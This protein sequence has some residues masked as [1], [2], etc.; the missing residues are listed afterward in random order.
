MIR[1]RSMRAG[2]R[3]RG[4]AAAGAAA[5]SG[6]RRPGRRRRP[7]AR[8]R[9]RA[10]SAPARPGERSVPTRIQVVRPLAD[11][12]D[13]LQRAAPVA[14]DAVE[15]V[16]AS[17]G[18][19]PEKTARVVASRP[20]DADPRAARCRPGCRRRQTV[21]RL[22]QDGV[23]GSSPVIVALASGTGVGR[24]ARG[25]GRERLGA[26]AQRR[27]RKVGSGADESESTA[28]SSS[29]GPAA[30]RRPTWKRTGWFGRH[31]QRDR[32]ARL[33][34][35]GGAAVA[36]ARAGVRD[37]CASPL[38]RGSPAGVGEHLGLDERGQVDGV[39]RPPGR[40][41][42]DLLRDGRGGDENQTVRANE[43][44]PRQR[45]SARVGAWP[46]RARRSPAA[47]RARRSRRC[48]AR[49]RKAAEGRS[50]A[51]GAARATAG[52]KVRSAAARAR[53][54]RA[55][56]KGNEPGTG[57]GVLVRRATGRTGDD[58]RQ[59]GGRAAAAALSAA[60]ASCRSRARS[61]GAPADG[62]GSQ[63][64]AVSSPSEHANA[65]G[66]PT[67]RAPRMRRM[68]PWAKTMRVA[69]LRPHPL[70][71]AVDALARRRERLSPGRAVRPQ[72][73]ARPVRPD[74]AGGAPL[75]LAVAELD[76]VLGDLEPRTAEARQPGG[77]A[78]ADERAGETQGELAARE[79]P[80]Q[81]LRGGAAVVE[82]REVGAAVC[83]PERLHSV[84]PWRTS[85]R[86]DP[87]RSMAQ[88][89]RRPEAPAPV[90]APRR[91][92]GLDEPVADR[93]AGQLDP[94]AHAELGED[95][96]AVALHRPRADRQQVGDLLAS[97][98]T[99]R[100]AW[101]PPARGRSAARPACRRDR[102]G[103][104][105]QRADGRGV[106][107]RLAAHRRAAGLDEIAVGDRLEHVAATRPPSAPRSSTPPGRAS[108][109][110]ARAAPG[111]GARA[112]APPAG[113]CGAAS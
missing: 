17:A 68:W 24:F 54:V 79:P 23:A 35:A 87:V 44:A 75:V 47:P 71:D 64:A 83:W 4:Q 42:G 62:P 28:R 8:R 51:G 65:G 110:S 107:E 16:V 63:S 59:A 106:Q 85:S 80:A 22:G 96:L 57:R 60:D 39:E 21:P 11:R 20:V 66:R 78:S 56:I 37:A 76:Q 113:R 97:C 91:G 26:V 88:E 55:A 92:S 12:H 7:S 101:R 98:A 77:V 1:A 52:A 31:A 81:R 109:A 112:R 40:V 27:G 73:P 94:V 15:R 41:D 10:I 86:T 13:H 3:S 19:A 105:H 53:S 104:A 14:V 84:S 18:R 34:R 82:E 89:H 32:G 36:D 70:D 90:A 72:V 5:A 108:R 102:R 58:G 67:Q 38:A 49:S 30:P 69:V 48:T 25:R 93:P 95:V 100:R 29:G 9:G 99:R 74:V 111:A 46:R 50:F 33:D 61:P 6:R 43:P 103:S 2:G 45:G